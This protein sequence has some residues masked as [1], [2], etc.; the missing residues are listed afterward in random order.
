MNLTLHTNSVHDLKGAARRWRHAKFQFLVIALS[1]SLLTALISVLL[2]VGVVVG[3]DR[4]D[5]V[6]SKAKLVTLVRTNMSNIV[7]PVKGRVRLRVVI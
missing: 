4:P 3:S 6:G 2:Q 7:K 5:F 1:V